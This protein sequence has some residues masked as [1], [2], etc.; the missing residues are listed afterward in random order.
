MEEPTQHLLPDLVILLSPAP[1]EH[2]PR[3]GKEPVVQFQIRHYALLEQVLQKLIRVLLRKQVRI[4]AL[5]GRGGNSFLILQ[6][7]ALH[8]QLPIGRSQLADIPID[9]LQ[10]LYLAQLRLTTVLRDL[11]L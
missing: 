4:Y 7:Q 6:Q 11:P 3:F 9:L 10:H 8:F 5:R 1:C 2:R